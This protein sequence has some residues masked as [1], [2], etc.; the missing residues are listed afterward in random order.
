MSFAK[1]KIEAL[2]AAV[3]A[4][5]D[6]WL[7]DRQFRF[8]HKLAGELKARGFDVGESSVRRYAIQ[9]SNRQRQ[10][11]IEKFV[12]RTAVTIARTGTD[13]QSGAKQGVNDTQ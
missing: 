9:L 7:I 2:P 8:P 10:E 13:S 6:Q 11:R 4:E 5:I 12:A 1:Y 3:Q